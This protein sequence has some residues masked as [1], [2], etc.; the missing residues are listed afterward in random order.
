MPKTFP[1]KIEVEEIALGTVLR[2]LNEMPGIAKLHLDLGHGGQ[3]AG[4]KQLEQYAATKRNGGNYEQIVVK[5]LLHGPTLHFPL[6]SFR[7]SST[8][9]APNTGL[10]ADAFFDISLAHRTGV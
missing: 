6:P 9:L 1:I 2:R 8:N 5:L 4:A 10:R 3:G 7:N